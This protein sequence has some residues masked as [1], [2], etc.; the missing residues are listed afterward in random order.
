MY[1]MTVPYKDFKGNPHTDKVHFN[2]TE[3]EVFKLLVEFQAIFDW[4]ESIKGEEVRELKTEEVIEF[5]NNFETV[6]LAA[7]GEPSDDGRF[8]RK[9]GRYE[10]EES[11]AFAACMVELV[12]DPRKVNELIDALMPKNLQEIVQKSDANMAA[13]AKDE[14]S[15]AELRAQIAQLQAQI[16]SQEAS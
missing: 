14:G 12:S 2:L 8:F 10:F 9:S 1:T 3:H 5:Y 11:A 16:K 15:S 13:M 4:I 7:Y 6:L